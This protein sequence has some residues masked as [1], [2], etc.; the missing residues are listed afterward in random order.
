MRAGSR[1]IDARVLPAKYDP[2]SR[3]VDTPGDSRIAVGA[4]NVDDRPT[5]PHR[6]IP[7]GTT[8]MDRPVRA[9][10]D[11]RV[12]DR[13]RRCWLRAGAVESDKRERTAARWYSKSAAIIVL[14]RAEP[15]H[16]GR[17]AEPSPR[18]GSDQSQCPQPPTRSSANKSTKWPRTW[19]ASDWRWPRGSAASRRTSRGSATRSRPISSL[20]S[21]LGSSSRG[22]LWP[23]SSGPDGWSGM[24]RR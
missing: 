9:G 2:P 14:T 1:P 3:A 23:S 4:S 20:S 6:P 15:A 16:Q 13:L 7:A 12:R 10:P 18:I 19:P 22:S 17:L 24:P 8:G 5:R 21:G 11:A